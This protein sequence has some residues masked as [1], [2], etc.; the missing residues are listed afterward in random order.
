M[1]VFDSKLHCVY[2]CVC[3]WL[4]VHSI[5]SF[6]LNKWTRRRHILQVLCSYW[7]V[8]REI[9]PYRSSEGKYM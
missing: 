9:E 5:Q 8:C 2:V 1:T 3:V 7:P 4:P 6:C